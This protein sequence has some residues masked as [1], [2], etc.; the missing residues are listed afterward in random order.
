[1]TWDP[2]LPP[3]WGF[4]QASVSAGDWTWFYDSLTNLGSGESMFVEGAW[5]LFPPYFW[6]ESDEFTRW[7]FLMRERVTPTFGF[8]FG[9][10]RLGG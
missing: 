5:R 7:K 4:Y 9:G 3:D 10:R 1:M 2:A 6:E 8:R